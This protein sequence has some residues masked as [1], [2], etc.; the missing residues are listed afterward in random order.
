MD[1]IDVVAVVAEHLQDENCRFFVDRT[2]YPPGSIAELS[3]RFE[4]CD[5]NDSI[6]I[7]GRTPDI[8]GYTD[9]TEIFAVEAKGTENIRKGIG[10]AAHYRQGV[11]KSYVA[12]EAESIKE[13]QDTILA[14]GLGIFAVD[15][16]GNVSIES[17]M[18][19]V[20]STELNKTR[21]ALAIKTSS[22]VSDRKAFA[23]TTMPLNAFLPVVILTE[24][25]GLKSSMSNKSCKEAIVNHEYGIGAKTAPH[26][27]TL[28]K[29][30]QL[31]ERADGIADGVQLTDAGRMGYYLLRGKTEFPHKEEPSIQESCETILKMIQE[32]KD[33]A[34][35]RSIVVY[36]SDS[37]VAAFLRDRYLSIPD[38]RLMVRVLSAH[39]GTSG[40][41]SRIL[42][43]IA[44][45][46]PE[47]YLNLFIDYR[48]ESDFKSLMKN[49]S[50]DVDDVEFQE[51]M[52][53]YASGDALYNF[54]RQLIHVKILTAD[55]DYVHQ[56]DER[57]RGEFFWHWD[58]SIVGDLG[59]EGV[60]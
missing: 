42:A 9:D 21:R 24:T 13:F 30:L 40:E 39:P 43:E 26:L 58:P 11:Q 56:K 3:E 1:E 23:S 59:L 27:L 31:L 14:S 57:V 22:F 29:T 36:E 44:T 38:V 20:A 37:E 60:W 55:S 48:R 12:A 10:Q 32:W 54:V 46:A 28:A 5:I 33:D 25:V 51:K 34:R 16:N 41:L 53:A 4:N 17:P 18:E 45:E 2:G 47:V 52:L 50:F 15:T 49:S 19:A 35:Y 6:R 7:A 8:I